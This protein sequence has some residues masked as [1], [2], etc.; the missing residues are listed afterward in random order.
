M[1]HKL[2]LGCGQ[3]KID[4]FI[5]VDAD[6]S[7]G[8]DACFD[9][10]RPFPYEKDSC[11]LVVMYHTIEHI[12]KCYWPIIFLEISRVLI[13]DGEFYI[14]FPEFLKCVE[15]WKENKKGKREFWEHTIFGRGVNVLDNHVAIADSDQ[16][17]QILIQCG[18]ELTYI[19]PQPGTDG[20]YSLI[21]CK[22]VKA[23]TVE[24]ACLLEQKFVIA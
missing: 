23:L 24:D 5:N 10:R 17:R 1:L 19:G 14:T 16:M 21:K 3:G 9:I 11:S 12:R 22:N 8:P 4:G 13:K 7:L 20:E 15:A 2:N 6:G 18:F